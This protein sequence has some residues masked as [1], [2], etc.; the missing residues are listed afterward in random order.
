VNDQARIA[1]QLPQLSDQASAVWRAVREVTR[2]L[3]QVN[4]TALKR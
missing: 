1:Q 3:Q 4:R 2:Q